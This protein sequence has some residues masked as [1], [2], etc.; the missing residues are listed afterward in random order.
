M[1]QLLVTVEDQIRAQR[2][3]LR[4]DSSTTIQSNIARLIKQFD[5]PRRDFVLSRIAYHLIRASDDTVLK[6]S[7]T[8]RRAGVRKGELLL[9][10]S[11]EGRRVLLT[12]RK[13][14]KEI[15]AEIVDRVTGRIKDRVRQE[16]W[17]R[18]TQ[19][20]AEIEATSVGGARVE[21]LR[22]WVESS[23]GTMK[24][25]AFSGETT[26]G[27]GVPAAVDSRGGCLKRLF[28]F[29]CGMVLLLAAVM[30]LAAIALVVWDKVKPEYE[31]RPEPPGGRLQIRLS[32]T[33]TIAP[34]LSTPWDHSSRSTAIGSVRDARRAGT[35]HARAATATS[36][37]ATAA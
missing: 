3:Q 15:E 33:L 36:A 24:L 2:V 30:I 18:V 12:V 27:E 14:L 5:L 22:E 31:P 25:E 8:L 9:L 28:K 13:L 11:P 37:A 32:V 23:V 26:I 7:T 29:G 16:V 19:K 4:L 34:P 17:D 20:L 21:R 10:V 6:P 1:A 35:A